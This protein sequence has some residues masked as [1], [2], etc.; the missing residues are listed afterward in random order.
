VVARGSNLVDDASGLRTSALLDERSGS[1]CL[2]R[3]RSPIPWSDLL[4]PRIVAPRAEG[5]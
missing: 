4:L 2:L 1:S 5:V 3:V